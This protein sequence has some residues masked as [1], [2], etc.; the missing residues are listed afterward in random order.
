MIGIQKNSMIYDTRSVFSPNRINFVEKF[1][2][3]HQVIYIGFIR[4]EGKCFPYQHV[5]I[6]ENFILKKVNNSNMLVEKH[7]PSHLMK[8]M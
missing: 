7:F 3:F 4:C 8:P 6:V 5:G 1:T 2:S